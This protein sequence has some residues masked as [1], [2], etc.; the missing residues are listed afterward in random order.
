[1]KSK[2]TPQTAIPAAPRTPKTR[3]PAGFGPLTCRAME[4]ALHLDL[5]CDELNDLLGDALSR[6]LIERQAYVAALDGLTET[7]GSVWGAAMTMAKSERP[8]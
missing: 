4:T 5:L 7:A 2:P 6:R 3:R 1:M 8:R